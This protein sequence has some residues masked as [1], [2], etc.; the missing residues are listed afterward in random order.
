MGLKRLPGV[1]R[2]TI[3]AAGTTP[4]RGRRV[5]TGSVRLMSVVAVGAATCAMWAIPAG[6]ASASVSSSAHRSVAL[7]AS[8][9]HSSKVKV[10]IG[11]KTSYPGE[12]VRLSASI[13][14]VGKTPKGSVKFLYGSKKLCDPRVSHRAAHCYVKFSAAGSYKIKAVY[15]GDSTHRSSSS[16]ATATVKRLGTSTA[17]TSISPGTVDA[18]SSAIV[19]VSVSTPSGTPAATGTVKVAPT[20]IVGPVDPSYLCTAKVIGGKGHCT[21]TPPNPSYGVITYEATYSGSASHA[22]SKSTGDHELVVPDTTTTTVSPATGTV[23]PETLTATVVDEGKGN[24]SPSAGGTGTV[25]FTI[26]GNAEP[27]FTCTDA[28]LTYDGAG[29]NVATCAYT[30]PAAGSYTVT[31]VYSGDPGNLTSTGTETLVVS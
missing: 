27:T 28:A 7:A 10:S 30:P 20:D 29:N 1:A 12:S 19:S 21:V 23:G 9:R 13:V 11:P 17:I 18:G 31:A 8:S 14:T 5:G 15:S 16:K 26:T 4:R 6:A 22:G 24:I 25:T 2:K 3:A